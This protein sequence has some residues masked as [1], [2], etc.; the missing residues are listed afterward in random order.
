MLEQRLTDLI[1]DYRRSLLKRRHISKVAKPLLTNAF[2]KG[3]MAAR[4]GME[5]DDNP[6]PCGTR[7]HGDWRAGYRA[8]LDIAEAMDLD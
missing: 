8:S 7:D 4:V 6:Y 2:E 3:L 5:R 1:R